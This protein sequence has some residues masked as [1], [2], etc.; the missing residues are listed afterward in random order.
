MRSIIQKIVKYFFHHDI[1]NELIHR[2]HERMI[3]PMK[4]EERDEAM[5][6]IWEE[7]KEATCSEEEI[8]KAFLRVSSANKNYKTK[9]FS[10]KRKNIHWGKIAATWFLPFLML[11]FSG[12]LFNQ[13]TKE[14]PPTT[15]I[16]RYV[17]IGMREKIS[18]PDGST[19]WLNA[20][21]LLVYP[22]S[23][24]SSNREVYLL[25]EGFFNVVKDKDRP[26]IIS[27]NQLKFEVL[28]TT[29]NISSY[30]D[31]DEIK[32]T[33]ETGLL[34]VIVD[35]HIRSYTIK[36]NEQL[37]YNCTTGDVVLNKVEATAYSDWR[38]GGLFFN[39]LIFNDVL[40]TLERVYSV[41]FHLQT[42]SYNEQRI[43]V[44]LN[45]NETLENTMNIIKIL[46]PGIEYEIDGKNVYLK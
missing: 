7:M 30:P 41:K 15:Y 16:Q 18:L 5:F 1:S 13:S 6:S 42:S 17:P 40:R 10:R 9:D 43:R 20:G 25:G 45:K 34:K 33:L 36:P 32:A 22:S 39:D 8:E 44:H 28:G 14:V 35:K 37:V 23:F 27:S 21:S 19:A 3:Y 38:L 12:Y 11:C 46:I 4:D 29:F 26:F 31:Q 2:V 24:T